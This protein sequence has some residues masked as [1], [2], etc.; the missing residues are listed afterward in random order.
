M[1]IKTAIIILISLFV[2]FGIFAVS[3]FWLVP[4]SL[5]KELLSPFKHNDPSKSSEDLSE[6]GDSSKEENVLSPEEE[7][8][9][10]EERREVIVNQLTEKQENE[11]NELDREKEAEEDKAQKINDIKN[12]LLK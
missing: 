12:L 1:K 6:N 2:V 7:K 10:K 5:E 8:K 11:S 9:I 4:D 3:V